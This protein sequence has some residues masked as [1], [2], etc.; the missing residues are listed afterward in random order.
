MS[1]RA[2]LP[3]SRAVTPQYA[4]TPAKVPLLARARPGPGSSQSLLACGGGRAAPAVSSPDPAAIVTALHRDGR[5]RRARRRRRLLSRRHGRAPCRPRRRA[6]RARRAR[7]LRRRVEERGAGRR[8]LD[9]PLPRRR[10]PRALPVRAARRRQDARR[11]GDGDRFRRGRGRAPVDVAPPPGGDGGSASP[12][13]EPRS[14]DAVRRGDARR[15]RPRARCVRGARGGPRRLELRGLRS[16]PR[17]ERP[18]RLVADRRRPLA[19]GLR[20]LAARRCHL[21]AIG[22]RRRRTL[23]RALPCGGRPRARHRPC[24]GRAGKRPGERRSAR[25][26][27]R[28]SCVPATE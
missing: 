4:R 8:R 21:G 2:I 27:P 3:A 7:R 17:G 19:R 10:L 22:R 11:R 20:P 15:A 26:A 9:G 5:P 18:E 12:A 16:A 23:P 14:P 13:G 1:I 28:C 24:A 25:E 6:L